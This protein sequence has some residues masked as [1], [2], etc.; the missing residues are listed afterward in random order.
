MMTSYRA[1]MR[2]LLMS[3]VVHYVT[4]HVAAAGGQHQLVGRSS[5][6]GAFGNVAAGGS[7]DQP[8]QRR[9][10][11]S[12]GLRRPERFGDGRGA[13]GGGLEIVVPAVE[14]RRARRRAG[15]HGREP[16]AVLALGG[17]VG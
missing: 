10:H 9:V 2:S 6:P 8:E 12:A 3:P 1:G 17:A 11:G 7:R 15:T 4:D 5:L 16:A 13:S 14:R